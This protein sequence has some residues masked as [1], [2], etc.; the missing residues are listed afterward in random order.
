MPA[1]EDGM[2]FSAS[3]LSGHAGSRFEWALIRDE[4]VSRRAKEYIEESSISE[5][6]GTL[7]SGC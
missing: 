2:L 6:P 1:D 3:K 7:N 4:K 5:S